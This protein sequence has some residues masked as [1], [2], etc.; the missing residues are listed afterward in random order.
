MKKL[1]IF[2]I[3]VFIAIFA[4]AQS[5]PKLDTSFIRGNL[6][7]KVIIS[8]TE[9]DQFE[10]QNKTDGIF[11]D[12]QLKEL[13]AK[14]KIKMVETKKNIPVCLLPLVETELAEKETEYLMKNK[15]ITKGTSQIKIK[16]ENQKINWAYSVL[17]IFLPF[18]CIIIVAFI[19]RKKEDGQRKFIIFSLSTIAVI[20]IAIIIGKYIGIYIG[21]N[22]GLFAG[23]MIGGLAGWIVGTVTGKLIGK[24]YKEFVAV[25]AGGFAGMLA[26]GFAGGLAGYFAETLVE[27]EISHNILWHY[28]LL[29]AGVCLLG[30]F[31]RKIKTSKVD[32]V[33]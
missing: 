15:K 1:I 28:V 19:S 9:Q 32:K 31:L 6:Q 14:G 5:S 33:T 25:L 11:P 24:S 10:L 16:K 3:L 26:G 27:F 21:W 20:C 30:L 29:Y 13:M 7:I 2:T 22:T 12:Q 8:K 4:V 18:I 23:L 17:W